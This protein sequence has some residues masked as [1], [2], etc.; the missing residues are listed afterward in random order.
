MPPRRAHD[1]TSS[2]VSWVTVSTKR[3]YH[4][5]TKTQSLI[6]TTDGHRLTRMIFFV[7]IRVYS[8]PSEVKIVFKT[9]ST[10]CPTPM[11]FMQRKSIGHSRKKHGEHGTSDFKME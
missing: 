9:A 10:T 3:I 2:F 5:D 1:A 11:P 4:K 6:K 7:S 8:C